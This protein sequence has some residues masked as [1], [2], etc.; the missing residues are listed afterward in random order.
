MAGRV[1]LA[2]LLAIAGLQGTLRADEGKVRYCFNHWPPYA[3]MAGETAGGISVE[4]LREAT[5]RAGM[6]ASFL[7]IP[8]NRCLEMVRKGEIDAVVDA[9]ERP[10]YLQGK[11]SFSYYTNTFWVRRDF[12]SDRLDMAALAAKT[13]GLVDGYKYPDTVWS[14]LD[15]AGAKVDYSVDDGANI[16]KLAFGRVDAII[17]DFVGTLDFVEKNGLRLKPLSPTHSAD[18]LYTSFNKDRADLLSRVDAALAAMLADGSVDRIYRRRLGK[19]F[20]EIKPG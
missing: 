1:A 13:V 11:T 20:N 3:E 10:E 17:G 6:T 2:A 19:T 5:A 4:I 16:R 18:R 14:D 12:P 7:E 15:K 8:W 9:M